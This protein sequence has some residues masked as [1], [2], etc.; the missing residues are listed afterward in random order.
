M[1]SD[2]LFEEIRPLRDH[3]VKST[4]QSL[5]NDEQFVKSMSSGLKGLMTWEELKQNLLK[6]ENVFQFQ[7]Y[8]IRPLICQLAEKTVTELYTINWEKSGKSKSNLI[9]SNHRDIILD[10]A[11]LNI[12]MIKFG[13]PTTE[14]AIGDNLLIYQWIRD[15][16]RLN[17]SFIVKRGV[18]VRQMLETS[19]QLSDYIHNTIT[20]NSQSIWLAQREGRAKDS[21]D[22][23]Q[24]SL[25]KMLSLHDSAHLKETLSEL[26]ILPLALSYELDP[27]DFLKAKEFQLKRDNPEYK[28]TKADDLE[29][30]M[31]GLTGYKGRVSLKFGNDINPKIAELGDINDKATILETI[32]HA[33]DAE[34]FSNYVFYPFNYIAYD[35]MIGTKTCK[36]KYSDEDVN[37]FNKYMDA[38]LAKIDIPNKDDKF[39]R[40]RMV[41]MY[42]NPVRN[43][44]ELK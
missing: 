23:T 24:T 39:L 19:K 16:V 26:N 14:I 43:F 7:A 20:E 32:A 42:G 18:S 25:L 37:R 34:I 33:I 44:L 4:I 28:K 17:K 6:I 3:E 40:E 11:F 21:N 30:M 41:E 27:C 8:V 10:S 15:V 9:I 29:N 13:M 5:I 12:S 35:E 36:N 2:S 22:R 1:N 31:T 38:Q